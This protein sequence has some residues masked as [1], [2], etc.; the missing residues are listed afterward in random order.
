MSA[1]VAALDLVWRLG[2]SRAR[3]QYRAVEAVAER[4]AKP[5]AQAGRKPFAHP[6]RQAAHQA[7]MR[8]A[9][10]QKTPDQP[11]YRQSSLLNNRLR[12]RVAAFGMVHHDWCKLRVIRRRCTVRPSDDLT[13]GATEPVEYLPCHRSM[14]NAFI[15]CP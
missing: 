5:L 4:I 1:S 12:N 13:R 2:F 15:A 3:K 11:I 14:R 7:A 6:C 10:F 9:S 8:G